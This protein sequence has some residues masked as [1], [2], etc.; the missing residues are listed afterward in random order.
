MTTIKPNWTG[1]LTTA[2]LPEEQV[3]VTRDLRQERPNT[4]TL[5]AY[6]P[7][8]LCI[9]GHSFALISDEYGWSTQDIEISLSTGIA[10]VQFRRLDGEPMSMKDNA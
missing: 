10:Q 1:N 3:L 6:D 4:T 2:N 5:F 8:D 7:L 9:M